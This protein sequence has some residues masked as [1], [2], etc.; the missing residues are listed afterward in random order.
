MPRKV[1]QRTAVGKHHGDCP[2]CLQPITTG[3]K[4]IGVSEGTQFLGWF[5]TECIRKWTPPI[6]GIEIRERPEPL[7]TDAPETNEQEKPE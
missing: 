1:G 4:V 6:T 7:F 2:G 3:Q 5:C